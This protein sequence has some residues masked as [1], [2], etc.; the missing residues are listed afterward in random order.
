MKL[1]LLERFVIQKILP[2]EG[3]FAT[4]KILNSLK[5]ALAPSE[6]EFKEFGIKD[7]D[8]LI[9]WNEKGKEEKEMELGEKKR[10]FDN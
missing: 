9:S 6:E 8:G 4:L 2:R 1:N 7:Q 10:A 3:D 5:M